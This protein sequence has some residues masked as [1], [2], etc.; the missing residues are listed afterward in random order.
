M[1]VTILNEREKKSIK[2]N[3]FN[4]ILKLSS[5]LKKQTVLIYM[6]F[7]VLSLVLISFYNKQHLHLIMNKYNSPFFDVFF[8][9][10][11]YLGDGVLFGILFLVFLFI[12]KRIAYVFAISGIITLLVTHLFK[13]II[14]KGLPRPT[15]FFGVEKL[16]LIEGVEMAFQNTFPSGYTTTAFTIFTILCLCKDKCNFQYLW[17][18]LAIIAGV[19]R[20]CLSQHYWIDIFV[21]SFIGIII[22]F[23]S[24]AIFYKPKRVH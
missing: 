8:K 22:G 16:H 21:G 24:M 4:R 2:F 15:G 1:I 19:S 10:I 20:V 7:F 17:V 12:K 6:M 13:Q 3:F 23:V 5:L 18:L 9:Y 11:T 14:F